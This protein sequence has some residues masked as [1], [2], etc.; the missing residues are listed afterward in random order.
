MITIDEENS[1]LCAAT[2]GAISC[3]F[4][5]D[6]TLYGCLRLV[7]DEAVPQASLIRHG[8]PY[9]LWKEEKHFDYI[10]GFSIYILFIKTCGRGHVAV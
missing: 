5:L 3:Y 6:Y 2:M 4:P 1:N 9:R 8:H 7:K 10:C